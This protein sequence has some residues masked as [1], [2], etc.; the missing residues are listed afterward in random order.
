MS[1]PI[2]M[3]QSHFDGSTYI[4]G[5]DGFPYT[6]QEYAELLRGANDGQSL[7][8]LLRFAAALREWAGHGMSQ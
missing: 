2:G 4:V 3:M 8:Q 5:A 7:D 1:E 6:A